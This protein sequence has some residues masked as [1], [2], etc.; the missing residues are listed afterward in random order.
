MV[1]AVT[2]PTPCPFVLPDLRN[3]HGTDATGHSGSGSSTRL[4]TGATP[5]DA[6][7]SAST[8]TASATPGAKSTTRQS[9]A[10]ANTLPRSVTSGPAPTTSAADRRT[11][12][13]W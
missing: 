2:A 4:T 3:R 12:S 11:G 9:A 8:S 13:T 10:T 7:T 5:L 1:I 6:S